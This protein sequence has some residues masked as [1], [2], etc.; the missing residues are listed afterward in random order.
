M[1]DQILITLNR[2]LF[3]EY[4]RHYF[5]EHPRARKFPFRKHNT[6]G[7]KLLYNVLSLNDILPIDYRKYKT[8]KKQW[9]DFGVWVAKK[10]DLQGLDINNSMIEI[11]MF[12]ETRAHRD[13]DNVAGGHKLFADGA[14]VDSGMLKDDSFMYINPFLITIDF[15]KTEP[16]TE[17]RIS[18]FETDTIDTYDKLQE[19][20]NNWRD[21]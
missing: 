6:K 13:C 10:Y 19:H 9:G 17:I 15:D 2:D 7:K 16:R 12:A 5:T 4:E 20:L 11:R 21:Y 8:L 1:S 14:Y 18:T 3:A